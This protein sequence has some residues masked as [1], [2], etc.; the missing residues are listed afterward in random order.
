MENENN[1]NE[2]ENMQD[3]SSE[4]T[5]PNYT[6][7][8]SVENES[9]NNDSTETDIDASETDSESSGD[10]DNED[11][12]DRLDEDISILTPEGE[13]NETSDDTVSGNSLES[14]SEGSSSGSNE[15]ESIDGIN[16][17]LSLIRSENS[18][19]Y[20][21]TLLIQKN[22]YIELQHISFLM[23]SVLVIS[24]VIG[25]FAVL[26]VGGKIADYFFGKMKG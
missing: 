20:K 12:T 15:Y 14:Y 18:D 1:I 2:T 6:S 17:V 16:E 3:S 13:E 21:E 23:E 22:M 25:F 7:E 5:A 10:N 9:V 4:T 24:A 26:H 19:Y 11:I 8:S